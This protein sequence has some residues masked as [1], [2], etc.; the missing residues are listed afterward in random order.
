LLKTDPTALRKTACADISYKV[1]PSTVYGVFSADPTESSR[2]LS[3]LAGVEPS[4]F[5]RVLLGGQEMT[6]NRFKIGYFPSGNPFPREHTVGELLEF[7]AKLKGVK[8]SDRFLAVGEALAL[9][10]LSHIK[11]RLISSLSG[12]ELCRL[13]VAQAWIGKPDVLL[14]DCQVAGLPSSEIRFL[15]RVI[16]RIADRGGACIFLS[17]ARPSD[18]FG[19]ADRFF[20]LENGE[21]NGPLTQAEILSGS[22]V[23]VRVD[24]DIRKLES[25]FDRIEHIR[26]YRLLS[27]VGE[28]LPIYRLRSCRSGIAESVRNAMEEAGFSVMECV[29]EPISETARILRR[30]GVSISPNAK[31]KAK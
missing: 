14:L 24:G 6:P 27:N 8:S 20:V 17:L 28:A 16:C 29:E 5:G 11:Q 31:E 19:F 21:A 10:E 2:F 26:S 15:R 22:T 12:A 25:L 23:R 7:V 3:C 30:A 4:F 18:L 9:T 1:N 13:G